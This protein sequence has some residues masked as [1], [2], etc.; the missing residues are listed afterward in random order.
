[1]S[2]KTRLVKADGYNEIFNGS[3]GNGRVELPFF[4][5]GFEYTT[6]ADFY[7]RDGLA[8]R[9]ID[10]VP[11]E[12]VTPGCLN[13]DLLPEQEAQSVWHLILLTIESLSVF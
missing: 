3:K 6:H 7:I 13:T 8:K 11:E 5:Q 1:M 9:I 2:E 12:M 10:V 4:M